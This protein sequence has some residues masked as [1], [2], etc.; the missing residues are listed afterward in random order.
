MSNGIYTFIM[1]YAGGTYVSQVEALSPL[2][3]LKVWAMSLDA[4]G[5]FGLGA[6]GKKQLVK[7][8]TEETPAVA[9]LDQL[10]NAWCWTAIA[11]N[12]LALV[13]IVGTR[14]R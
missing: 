12:N 1:D 3:A 5:I 9:P 11:R 13:N 10:I 7:Q 2:E 4:A 6:L 8:A 14:K